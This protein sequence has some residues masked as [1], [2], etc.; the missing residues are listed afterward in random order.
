MA[1]AQKW[2]YQF[3]Q[4][5]AAGRAQGARGNLRDLLGGKGAGAAE[6]TKAGMPVPPGVTITTA[7]CRAYYAKGRKFPPGTSTW[8]KIEH[9]LF[10]HISMNWRGRPHE[11]IVDLI[12]A[13]TTKQG[14]KVRAQSDT[15]AYPTSVNVSDAQMRAIP[16]CLTP[17]MGEWNYTIISSPLGRDA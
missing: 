14:L 1:A 15:G 7:A 2:V 5:L 4:G 9:R 11:I 6:M 3:S 16:Y 10:S 12:A 8:N 13:K 17:S